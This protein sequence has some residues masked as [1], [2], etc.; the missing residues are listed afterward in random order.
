MRLK[1]AFAAIFTCSMLAGGAV[2]GGERPL[3]VSLIQLI[4][5]PERFDGKPVSVQGFLGS[6]G[7][8]PEFIGQFPILY[9]H[10]EDGKNLLAYN[11]V[12]VSPSKQM[13]RDR[14]KINLM[15]VKLTGVFRA[16]RGPVGSSFGV[17][18]I[19]D[20]ESCTAWSDPA[21]P[22]GE[23]EPPAGHGKYK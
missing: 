15:Y 16:G 19:T 8:H 2:L 23:R 6:L 10:Q 12:W 3:P 22:A 1:S 14:E 11:S 7:E 17:G 20:V 5:N 13:Q 21:R 4:A 9:L 18:T